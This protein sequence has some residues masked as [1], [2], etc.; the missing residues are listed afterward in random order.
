MPCNL[1]DQSVFAM[2]ANGILIMFPK[3]IEG[4]DDGILVSEKPVY[5][6]LFLGCDS[7]KAMA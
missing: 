2:E 3:Q 6:V 7:L 4:M 5:S 1:I